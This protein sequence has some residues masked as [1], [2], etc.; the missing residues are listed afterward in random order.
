[1]EEEECTHT[2]PGE[3]GSLPGPHPPAQPPW[4]CRAGVW[5]LGPQF[6]VRPP[7]VSAHSAPASP[8]RLCPPPHNYPLLIQTLRLRLRGR[9]R[10]LS[11]IM[12]TH[13]VGP[14]RPGPLVMSQASCLC[15]HT[16]WCRLQLK[17]HEDTFVR[18]VSPAL[19]QAAVF[20]L[21]GPVDTVE[22][23]LSSPGGLYSCT[24]S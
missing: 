21:K 12:C 18:A 1:M 5:E 24:A 19:A 6:Y 3:G 8:L 22:S 15:P 11:T 10:C 7:H 17:S 4:S 23:F 14:T 9:G 13:S 20:V 16:L 2:W